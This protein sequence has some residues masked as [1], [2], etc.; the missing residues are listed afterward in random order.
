MAHL[1]ILVSCRF[2]NP[3][4]WQA[5]VAHYAQ[6]IFFLLF[7]APLLW[8]LSQFFF[9][10]SV[11]I[12]HWLLYLITLE[13]ASQISDAL[14]RSQ[15]GIALNSGIICPNEYFENIMGKKEPTVWVSLACSVSRLDV[16]A[17][18]YRG[19]YSFSH[20]LFQEWLLFFLKVIKG[21]VHWAYI[22]YIY[23]S[24]INLPLKI[25]TSV[26]SSKML[27]PVSSLAVSKLDPYGS[28]HLVWECE[29]CRRKPNLE[30]CMGVFK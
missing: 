20:P 17:L 27:M 28:Y 26:L 23:I 10:L 1:T 5:P 8:S 18:D 25:I 19:I 9:L 4:H 21:R 13:G 14:K 2:C 11:G 22:K 12:A 29:S 7:Y 6:R 30:L 24:C 15:E 16:E 3:P